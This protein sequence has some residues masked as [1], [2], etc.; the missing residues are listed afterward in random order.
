MSFFSVFRN[1]IPTLEARRVLCGA[2]VPSKMQPVGPSTAR[3]GVW[4]IRTLILRLIE[5]YWL[6]VSPR[7]GFHCA[8]RVRMDARSCSSFGFE[9]I[10]RHG[11]LVGLRLLGRRLAKCAEAGRLETTRSK[12]IAV[13]A[14]Y[15]RGHCDLPVGDCGSVHG[16][17]ASEILGCL[18]SDDG[19]CIAGAWKRLRRTVR[20]RRTAGGG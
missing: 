9:A 12:S 7:K 6:Y 19:G 13:R 10:R 20:S 15:Q 11:P 3:P 14:H 8:Y 2:R 18:P 5:I 4:T 17:H 16:C 1:A